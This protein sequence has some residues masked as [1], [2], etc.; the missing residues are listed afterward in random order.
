M[1]SFT[2]YQ[3]EAVIN[4][5]VEGWRPEGVC[6]RCISVHHFVDFDEV[7]KLKQKVREA[8]DD[9]TKQLPRAPSMDGIN[10][11]SSIQQ[12]VYQVCEYLKEEI[13]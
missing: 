6:H 4:N 13:K 5:V 7:E 9:L 1:K 10:S 2:W 8:I 3:C 12:K 11:W